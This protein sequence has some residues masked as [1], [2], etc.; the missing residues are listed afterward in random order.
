MHGNALVI[1]HAE[2]FVSA[3]VLLGAKVTETVSTAQIGSN[4]EHGGCF[5]QVNMPCF[6]WRACI[7]V[8]PVRMR[9]SFSSEVPQPC[10]AP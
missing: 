9:I 10:V 5:G 3:M 6:D 7:F 8:L 2:H 4:V 1:L